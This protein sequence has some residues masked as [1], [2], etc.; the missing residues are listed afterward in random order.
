VLT[1][2][3]WGMVEFLLRRGHRAY[4]VLKVYPQA[5]LNTIYARNHRQ[6]HIPLTRSA[7]RGVRCPGCQLR[8]PVYEALLCHECHLARYRKGRPQGVAHPQWRGGRTAGAAFVRLTPAYKAW[9]RAVFTRD[10]YRCQACG[11]RGGRLEADHMLPQSQFPEHR[12]DVAN[13]RTLCR[14]CHQQTPTYGSRAKRP[15]A[16]WLASMA[17]GDYLAGV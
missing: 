9:R 7:R 11:V 1:E 17:A 15:R 14:A 8:R 3:Q 6:W 5:N 2:S 4:D 13:G 10:D 16:Y 12:F